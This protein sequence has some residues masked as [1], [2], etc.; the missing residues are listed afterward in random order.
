MAV[1]CS[2][3]KNLIKSYTNE[4]HSKAALSVFIS[5]VHLNSPFQDDVRLTKLSLCRVIF[6]VV[7]VLCCNRLLTVSLDRQ[8]CLVLSPALTSSSVCPVCLSHFS[9]LL[10]LSSHSNLFPLLL[11]LSVFFFFFLLLV[12][13]MLHIVLRPG[14]S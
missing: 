13:C 7:V 4:C 8:L 6:Q 11:L 3:A 10:F 2:V 14:L 5:F 12:L 9:S 1:V